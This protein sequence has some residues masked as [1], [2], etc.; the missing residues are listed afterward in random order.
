MNYI[1]ILYLGTLL[2]LVSSDQVCYDGLGCFTNDYPF[3]GTMQRPISPLPESPAKI[4]TKFFLYARNSPSYEQISANNLGKMFSPA[5]LTKII[6]HGWFDS[7]FE[8]WIIEMKTALLEVGDF[9]VIA[10]DWEWGAKR[11]YQDSAAN[12]QI[13]AAE[14]ARL[15]QGLIDHRNTSV[16][17]IHLIGHSLGAHTVGYVGKRIKGISRISGLD[18][19]GPY[20]ENTPAE[21][22]LDKADALYVDNIHTMA[23]KFASVFSVGTMQALG[24]VDFYPN[25]GTSQP[26]CNMVSVC[27]HAASHTLFIDS[28]RNECPFFSYPCASSD[29]FD[30]GL[31]LRC[32]RN[33]CNRMG[34]WSSQKKDLNQLYLN[35]QSI[36]S[37]KLCEQHF[38][39]TLTSEQNDGKTAKGNFNIVLKTMNGTSASMPI[40]DDKTVFH[41]N[42]INSFLVSMSDRL[43]SQVLGAS[44][45][46]K[47]NMNFIEYAGAWTF[48]K[49]EIFSAETQVIVNLCPVKTSRRENIQNFIK[50]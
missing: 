9:N 46:Y 17:D 2:A 48:K 18:P 44:V 12:T 19:A 10:V 38:E 4:N 20:F 41:S 11:M 27:S 30:D 21:V 14:T 6:I 25:G 36:D 23:Y 22:R 15:I 29:A 13:A 49:I 32:G 39:V 28:I 40:D 31:C 24:H 45:S 50:C 26:G 43:T 33:G 5:K 1:Q 7:S 42:S 8:D 3:G 47:R 16:G 34:Y 35:T 37:A